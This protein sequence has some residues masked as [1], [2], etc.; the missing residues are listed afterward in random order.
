MKKMIGAL[1]FV[2]AL[3]AFAVPSSEASESR[4]DRHSRYGYGFSYHNYHSHYDRW[5]PWDGRY[6]Y[7]PVYRGDDYFPTY[8]RPVA[9]PVVRPLRIFIFPLI[10]VPAQE[11]RQEPAAQEST[12]SEKNEVEAKEV[13][14]ETTKKATDPITKALRIPQEPASGENTGANTFCLA[15][16]VAVVIV[17]I[18]LLI[19]LS[20]ITIAMLFVKCVPRW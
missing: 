9:Y 19:V 5:N 15:T 16:L 17:G 12:V 20:L 7:R 4:Y 10:R 2:L 3:L 11:Q 13:K 1:A 8:D 6:H 18:P 14:G